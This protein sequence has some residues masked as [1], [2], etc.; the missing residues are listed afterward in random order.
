MV[1]WNSRPVLLQYL[2]AEWI[3]LDL[4]AALKAGAIKAEIQASDAG[5]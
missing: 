1:F 3:D 2:A 5:E 4:E